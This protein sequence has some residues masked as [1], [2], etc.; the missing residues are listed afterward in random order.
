M[1]PLPRLLQQYSE[2]TEASHPR[3]EIQHDE[4]FVYLNISKE[5][6]GYTIQRLF[7]HPNSD[8]NRGDFMPAVVVPTYKALV[9][10]YDSSKGKDSKKLF[11]NVTRDSWY[12][13]GINKNKQALCK[14]LAFEPREQQKAYLT[15]QIHFP[16]RCPSSIHGYFL[17]QENSP[18]GVRFLEAEPMDLSNPITGKSL[19]SRESPNYAHNIM[20]HIGGFYQASATY[21]H[22]LWLGGSEGCFGFIPEKSLRKSFFEA[23]Q[24]TEKEAFISNATWINWTTMIEQYRDLDPQKRFVI[25]IEKRNNVIREDTKEI[26]EI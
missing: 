11:M 17:C 19:P 1:K 14:N 24:I 7:G 23:S 4:K 21:A 18:K 15:E 22:W 5:I 2:K 10:F 13:L 26:L 20:L 25:N 16:S 6:T 12:Y 3:K 9:M 8:W